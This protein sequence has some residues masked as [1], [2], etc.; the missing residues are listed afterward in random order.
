MSVALQYED[1]FVTYGEWP[2]EYLLENVSE[3]EAAYFD[4]NDALSVKDYFESQG[5]KLNLIIV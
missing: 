1:K 3:D 2:G 4:E 5:I